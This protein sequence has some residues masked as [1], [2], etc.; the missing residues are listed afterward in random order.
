[1]GE[2]RKERGGGAGAGGLVALAFGCAFG[3]CGTRETRLQERDL[4]SDSFLK[5]LVF[6]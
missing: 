5:F 6:F 2:R 4:P 1:M 3:G